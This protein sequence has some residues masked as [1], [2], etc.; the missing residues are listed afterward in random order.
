MS[1]MLIIYSLNVNLKIL[2]S[3]IKIEDLFFFFFHFLRTRGYKKN[4]FLKNYVYTRT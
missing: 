3:T 4:I 2:Y 1:L